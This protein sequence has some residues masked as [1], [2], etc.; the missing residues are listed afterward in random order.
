MCIHSGGKLIA[1][2]ARETDG[3][4]FYQFEFE[5]PLDPN[6]PRTGPKDK[7]YEGLLSCLRVDT[8]LYCLYMYNTN[9]IGICYTCI[10]ADQRYRALRAVCEQGQTVVRTSNGKTN[11]N[12]SYVCVSRLYIPHLF[13]YMYITH[14]NRHSLF[15][16]CYMYI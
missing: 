6:L 16:L 11:L 8:M 2:S 5:N 7:R 3:I 1:S 10:Q 9:D 13:L 15:S 14:W 4:V 12:L